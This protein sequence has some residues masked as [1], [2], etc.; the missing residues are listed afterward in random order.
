MSEF[1]FDYKCIAMGEQ[2]NGKTNDK[3]LDFYLFQD[4][5]EGNT[6][7]AQIY[8]PKDIQEKF[9]VA[10]VYFSANDIAFPDI[11]SGSVKPTIWYCNKN[12]GNRISELNYISTDNS[13][14]IK[15]ENG[16]LSGCGI[17]AFSESDDLNEAPLVNN[18]YKFIIN[19]SKKETISY[20]IVE[21]IGSIDVQIIY[22]LI[23][24]TIK[25]CVIQKENAKPTLVQDRENQVNKFGTSNEKL[26]FEL[27]PKGRIEDVFKATFR[28]D[29]EIKF[30]YRLAFCNPSDSRH[31]LLV[32]ESDFTMED[33]EERRQDRKEKNQVSLSNPKCP[34]CGDSMTPYEY[35]KGDTAIVSCKGKELSK[36]AKDD[37]LKGKLT[38]VCGKKLTE[39]SKPQGS[40]EAAYIEKDK[41]IIPEGY[42]ERPSMNVVVAGFPKSGKTIYLSS[43]F[44]MQNGGTARGI[45]SHPSV[46]KKIVSAYDKSK[47]GNKSVEEIKFFNVDE[48]KGYWLSEDCE[49]TRTSPTEEI[50]RRY[51]MT[52]GEN[53][54]AQ[55]DKG[56][57][58]KLSWHPIGYRLGNLGHAFF[59]DIPGEA[60]ADKNTKNVRA[61]DMADCLLAV[62]NG[63]NKVADSVN[64]KVDPVGDLLATLKRIPLLSKNKIDM[65]NIPI[66]IVFTKHDLKLTD[67]VKNDQEAELCFDENC[68][69][70]K[71]NIFEMLP[72]DGVYEGS[73][74][75]RHIDC[76]S[77]EFEHYLKAKDPT[78]F[79]E[80]KKNYKNIKFFT[81]SALG[82]DN[83]LGKPKD[84][85]KEVLFRPRRLRVELPII[86]LMYKKGLIKR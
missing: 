27:K 81:C 44:N 79:D 11:A 5:D 18:C 57:A 71:E 82:S 67:Y 46:L 33:K 53:V 84:K 26:V 37:R 54:E 9:A 55:T 60:F 23:R 45:Q 38:V 36:T 70:V 56:D 8:I 49:K 83:C 68:H 62:I 4:Y 29:D 86:W 72:K 41:L 21:S 75:E 50:K 2:A 22:P 34:Y 1:Y 35:K 58:D 73:E 76:S 13:I 59:Y 47:K 10:K 30:N 65:K 32:D 39:L 25:L 80:I 14:F 16:V 51:V 74:L 66:A 78:N 15:S 85:T 7:C 69:I 64:G 61:L 28:V 12:V 19:Y 77:Y 52:V 63:S 17:I 3:A 48:D 43:L 40:G 6:M 24:N 20:Q 42:A 31:Y